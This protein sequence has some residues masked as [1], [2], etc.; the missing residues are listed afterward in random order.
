ML[1]VLGLACV[2]EG[3]FVLPT[4]AANLL[5]VGIALGATAW[6]SWRLHGRIEEDGLDNVPMPAALLPYLGPLLIVLLLVKLF[7]PKQLSDHWVVHGLGLLLVALACVLASEPEFGVLLLAYLACGLWHLSLFHNHR[8]LAMASSA[9]MNSADHQPQTHGWHS[10]SVAFS[11]FGPLLSSLRR[12]AIWTLVA[13]LIGLPLYLVLP[14]QGRSSWNPRLLFGGEKPA[15]AR[16]AQTGFSNE[17]D[18]NR[19]GLVEVD[20]DVALVVQAE[21]ANGQPKLDMSALQRWRGAVLDSYFDGRWMAGFPVMVRSPS[22]PVGNLKLGGLTPP[23]PPPSALGLLTRGQKLPDLGPEQFF[24]TFT[25]EVRKAGGLFLA[26]PVA[27]Q[28]KANPADEAGGLPAVSLRGEVG[29]APM[30]HEGN[31]T[32]QTGMAPVRGEYSY[33]QVICPPPESDLSFPVDDLVDSL[34]IA[35]RPPPPESGITEWTTDLID[36]LAAKSAYGVT[37]DDVRT[38]RNADDP[39]RTHAG[40]KVA[41]ALTEYLVHSGEYTYTLDRKRD[42]LSIDPTLDFLENVKQG[43]CDRFAG[44]LALMLRSQGMLARI[45]KGF[46]GAESQGDGSYFIRQN[47]A[48]SWVELLVQ[49]QGSDGRSHW[50]W[51]TL[52]PTPSTTAP[53]PTPFSWAR[54]WEHSRQKGQTAWRE[55][56]FDYEGEQQTALLKDTLDSLTTGDS[57]KSSVTANKGRLRQ[58][59]F[60][61]ALPPALI[62]AIWLLVRFRPVW[63]SQPTAQPSGFPFYARLLDLLASHAGLRPQL[64]Q[65]PREFAEVARLRLATSESTLAVADLP[66]RFAALLY[67]A[68]YGLRPLNNEESQT[69]ER[70]LDQLETALAR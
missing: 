7:R 20:D 13:L 3:R 47:F 48:H 67:R 12:A 31:L 61:L 18:L 33:R 49:R 6:I 46:R 25:F 66:V 62:A 32:L 8:E 11:G 15:G 65:T 51:R 53:P 34:Q 1:V 43:H 36:R 44:A 16:M 19:T 24:L 57:A 52:D 4:W 55:L 10:F 22:R 59:V 41:L 30:F 27:Y 40:E 58:V 5:G 45:V 37:E 28:R 38:M 39:R 35:R 54:W 2:L 23:P 9:K 64:A 29:E 70:E 68:R 17:I 42:D 50:H 69:V 63:R 21:D 60:W 14:R 26:D 56:V